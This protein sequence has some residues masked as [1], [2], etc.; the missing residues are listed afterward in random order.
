MDAQKGQSLDICV[1]C[2]LS[3]SYHN[4]FLII[5]LES[6]TES[7]FCFGQIVVWHAKWAVDL[8]KT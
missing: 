3:P 7:Y 8:W 5:T 1:I 4:I 2:K 6:G